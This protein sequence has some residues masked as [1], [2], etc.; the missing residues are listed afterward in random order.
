MFGDTTAKPVIRKD[1][2]SDVAEEQDVGG[3]FEGE[4]NRERQV[5]HD[6]EVVVD[7]F[8]RTRGLSAG[9]YF[10]RVS[11]RS[12]V[13]Q[14]LIFRSDVDLDKYSS[15]SDFLKLVEASG[16]AL[17]EEDNIK[18]GSNWDIGYVAKQARQAAIELLHDLDEQR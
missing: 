16:G 12:A 6:R 4:S 9:T 10:M 17:A 1:E 7:L 18:Y 3:H 14:R 2:V 11:L 15:E 5:G 13:R 8:R